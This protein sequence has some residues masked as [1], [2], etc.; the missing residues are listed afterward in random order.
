MTKLVLTSQRWETDLAS[1]I[2]S[3]TEQ[4]LLHPAI[5]AYVLRRGKIRWPHI[6]EQNFTNLIKVVMV[7]QIG[8]KKFILHRTQKGE[9]VLQHED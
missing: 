8:Q 9:L 1:A 2:L 6:S 4:D 7:V 5:K 3:S